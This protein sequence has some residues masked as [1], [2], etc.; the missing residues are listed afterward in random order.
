MVHHVTGAVR[1]LAESDEQV[2]S[3]L[4]DWGG[5]RQ[6]AV[7]V[8]TAKVLGVERTKVLAEHA[9]VARD[10]WVASLRWGAVALACRLE[11]LTTSSDF[12]REMLVTR[13]AVCHESFHVEFCGLMAY[14]GFFQDAF[15]KCAECSI[16]CQPAA[17]K[18]TQADLD[19]LEWSAQTQR[20]KSWDLAYFQTSLPRCVHLMGTEALT[21][22]FANDPLSEADAVYMCE[23]APRIMD[24]TAANFRLAG[25][26]LTKMT[27]ILVRASEAPG[28][29]ADRRGL[30]L[31]LA[32]AH[33]YH[34][35]DV[36]PRLPGF[37]WDSHYGPGGQL[38][39]DALELFDY[40]RHRDLHLE[41]MSIDGGA[42]VRRPAVCQESFHIDFC[43]L[44]AYRGFFQNATFAWPMFMHF[45]D[46]E[47][48]NRLVDGALKNFAHAMSTS[49]VKSSLS[50]LFCH[51]S[52]PNML[53]LCGRSA[54]GI[55]VLQE[56]VGTTPLSEISTH[57]GRICKLFAGLVV[58]PAEG[59]DSESSDGIIHRDTI[60]YTCQYSMVLAGATEL[61]DELLE[62][63]AEEFAQLQMQRSGGSCTISQTW[64]SLSFPALAFERAGKVEQVLAFTAKS[65]EPDMAKAGNPVHAT[66][67]LASACRGRVLAALGRP[68][69]A[70]AAFETAAAE[71][72][73]SGLRLLQAAALYDLVDTKVLS[74]SAAGAAAAAEAEADAE[75]ELAAVLAAMAS[76][77]AELRRFLAARFDG[78]AKIEPP[79]QTAEELRQLRP[80]ELRKLA[81]ACRVPPAHIEA[82]DDSTAPMEA[83][84]QLV[85]RCNG[86][87]E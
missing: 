40:D 72:G 36:Q 38:L 86:H 73:G 47:K 71:A 58:I 18:C 52:V 42:V 10:M 54:D 2:E 25:A 60:I 6:D 75:A 50:K 5:V 13:P 12:R 57:L 51:F 45:G 46:L 1:Q 53:L 65:L 62:L 19:L 41:Q 84:L 74:A 80:S 17:G 23:I 21:K 64:G 81:L 70:A 39:I 37:S 61:T 30:M 7:V 26:A 87:V 49:D 82:A 11:G 85:L 44:M 76:P 55:A 31:N 15:T 77:D 32:Y 56:L 33:C 43:G 66:R 14:R 35:L 16:E 69:E 48:G 24:V 78:W 83:L 27:R 4:S 9:E 68:A 59:P 22:F 3:W 29:S 8:A 28:V 63:D 20:T 67:S 79:R 34:M